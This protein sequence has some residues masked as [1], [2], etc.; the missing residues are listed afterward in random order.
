M[1]ASTFVVASR[2]G[3]EIYQY[4][5]KHKVSPVKNMLGPMTQ[6]REYDDDLPL[7]Q[8]INSNAVFTF[9]F[10]LCIQI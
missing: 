1:L 6:V 3:L 8:A 10:L 2:M 9:T 4:M 7:S 5:K